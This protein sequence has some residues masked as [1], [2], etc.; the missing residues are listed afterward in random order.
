VPTASNLRKDAQ[1]AR[2]KAKKL[3]AFADALDAAAD[4]Q[5]GLRTRNGYGT[6]PRMETTVTQPPKVP[7]KRGPAAAA[8][9]PMTAVAK[10]KGIPSLRALGDALG[11]TAGN[12]RLINLRG[13][14]PPGVQKKIDALPNAGTTK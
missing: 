11:I 8:D 5:Q 6:V 9:G 12:V 1:A 14:I 7:R 2:E 4:A 10:Q 3:L 13:V